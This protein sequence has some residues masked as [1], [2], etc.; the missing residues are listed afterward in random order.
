MELRA[1]CGVMACVLPQDLPVLR[2]ILAIATLLVIGCT[3]PPEAE[4]RAAREAVSTARSAGAER[5]APSE[6][7][8]MTAVVKKA[9]AEMAAKAYKDAKASYAKAKIL[10]DAAARAALS[11]KAAAKEDLEKQLTALV[12]RWEDL[13]KQ[14]QVSAKQMRVVEKQLSDAN[15]RTVVEQLEAAKT[16]VGDDLSGAKEKLA[17]AS[18]ALDKWEQD[19]AH[20]GTSATR[21]PAKIRP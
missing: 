1:A 5:Y 13:E 18:A 7:V 19:L 15:A 6:Y 3:S 4:Q 21:S 14:T 8:T 2:L 20:R 17:S 10:A 12:R 11:G 16:A 9:E